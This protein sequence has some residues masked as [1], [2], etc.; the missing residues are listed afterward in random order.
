MSAAQLPGQLHVA[1]FETL[2]PGTGVAIVVDRWNQVVPLTIAANTAETNTL[3]APHRAGQKL[4]IFAANV[5]AS[6]S[7]VVT[8]ASAY[9]AAG[10]TTLT[11]DAVDE[12]VVLESVPVGSAG[13]PSYEWRVVDFEGVT[14]PT[15]DVGTLEIGGTA[16]TATAAEINAAADVSGRIVNVTD[17]ASYVVLAA[18][19]GKP[20]I[21][22][23]FTASC[24]LA[25]PAVAAGLEFE[26]FGKAV[27][28]DAQNWIFDTGAAANFYLGSLV[29]L[30]TDDPADTVTT[31]VFPNGSSNDILTIVT[32]AGGTRVKLI[33]D[34]TNWIVGGVVISATTPAFSDT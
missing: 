31:G 15:A 14:G 8:V 1:P 20:H 32:P 5:G 11:F 18:N 30:D 26:F 28:V 33:C 9:D 34:G 17:A 21:M 25:L 3:A 10:G 24:T 4:T 23:N 29:F 6:G 13:S 27:A 12:R 2:D 19:S 16:I 7:R 22:P